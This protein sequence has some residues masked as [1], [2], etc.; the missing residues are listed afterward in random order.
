MDEADKSIR[1]DAMPRRRA[2]PR[3]TFERAAVV[4]RGETA[5]HVWGDTEAG[6]VTDRVYVSSS[7]LHVLEFELEPGG[8]FRHS[9]TNKTV[10]AA[11]VMYCVLEGELVLAD[12]QHG[13]VRVVAP[14]EQVLFHRDTWHHGFNP[15][16][17]PLRVLEFFAPPPSR[18]TAS[19][20]ARHQS[21]LERV[22]YRDQRWSGR[23]PDARAERLSTTRLHVV[24]PDDA[25]WGFA[26]ESPTHLVG[27]LAD[28]E[29]LTVSTGRVYAGHVEDPRKVDDESMLVVTS[30]E[31]WVDVHEEDGETYATACLAA[32]DAVYVPAHA[33]LRV[34]S[35][36]GEPSTYLQGSGRQVAPGWTP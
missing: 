36:S 29:H 12:P 23:W 33:T 25:V 7:A 32:G 3:P 21:M 5:H 2:T 10:F 27:L 30:G 24:R 17:R 34:L 22:Q 20:Y 1:A 28:T 6:L 31:L 13:E 14:G 9:A 18:G 8:A 16:A 15:S 4:R 26:A 11:D 35:R 19:Q